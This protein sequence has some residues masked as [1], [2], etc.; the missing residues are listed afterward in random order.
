MFTFILISLILLPVASLPL[1]LTY[2]SSTELDEMGI[3]MENID[4]APF[5]KIMSSL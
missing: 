5:Q 3:C 2:F 4:E 1:A